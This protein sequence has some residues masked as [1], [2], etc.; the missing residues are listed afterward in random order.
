MVESIP[1]LSRDEPTARAYP[2]GV[3][4][5]LSS[6]AVTNLRV[7]PVIGEVVGF[8]GINAGQEIQKHRRFEAK[9]PS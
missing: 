9:L 8:F 5:Y 6:E 2:A 7:F 1:P 3:W 4:V